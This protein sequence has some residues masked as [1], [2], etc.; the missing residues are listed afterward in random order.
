MQWG[1]QDIFGGGVQI[2][3]VKSTHAQLFE[4]N[5]YGKLSLFHRKH[6]I[7]QKNCTPQLLN[8]KIQ[9]R[10]DDY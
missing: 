1:K 8:I 9:H 2:T 3:K 5:N 6:K 7:Q 4:A 10:D